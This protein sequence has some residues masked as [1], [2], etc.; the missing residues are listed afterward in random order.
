MKTNTTPTIRV[1]LAGY[2]FLLNDEDATVGMVVSDNCNLVYPTTEVSGSNIIATLTVEQVNTLK[3]GS[4][5]VEVFIEIG[6]AIYRTKTLQ[7]KLE[8]SVGVA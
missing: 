8:K 3:P 1:C 6:D 2:D 4:I 7:T 5:N